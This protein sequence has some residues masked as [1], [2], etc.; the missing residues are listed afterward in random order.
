MKKGIDIKIRNLDLAVVARIDDLAEK[1]GMNRTEYLRRHLKS[2]ACQPEIE[3]CE[4]R[5][6]QLV[7]AV[8][9]QMEINNTLLES[10]IHHE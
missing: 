1:K 7:D 9:H 4:D 6:T 3:E 2:L 10:L 8:L 5:Y